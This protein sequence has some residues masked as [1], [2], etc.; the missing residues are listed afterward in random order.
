MRAKFAWIA[1]AAVVAALAAAVPVAAAGP[2]DG[3]VTAFYW[4]SETTSEFDGSP[5]FKEDSDDL[6]FR[7]ELWFF[8]RL[9]VSAGMY[10]ADLADSDET[11][12][13]T[14]L[15]VEWRLISPSENNFFAVGV[16]WQKIDVGDDDTSGPRVVVE[17]RVALVGIL[18]FYGRGA[19]APDLDDVGP[20]TGG[21]ASEYDLGVM[22]KP[23]PFLQIFAG[24]R[25]N[26]VSFDGFDWDTTGPIAG[27]G[28]NF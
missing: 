2:V 4:L 8:K 5:S 11:V 25:S 6:G 10:S 21:K 12:D 14:N 3:E 20:A 13:Y 18:Y 17:G 15:D 26:R 27:V 1:T 28:I 16:G 23:A 7:G 9:G 22:I 19:Y 24:Y